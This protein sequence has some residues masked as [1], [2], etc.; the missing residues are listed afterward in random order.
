MNKSVELNSVGRRIPRID[1]ADKVTGQAR[2]TGDIVVAGML[3][4]ALVKSSHARGKIRDI[5]CDEALAV[6]GVVA[7][8]TGHD[9]K[10]TDCVSPY[11][12]VVARDRRLLPTDEVRFVG[13]AVAV[14]VARSRDIAREAAGLVEIDV[15]E[16]P[17][18]TTLSEAMAPDAPLVHSEGYEPA[19]ELYNA[20]A[21]MH[22]GSSNV[23]MTYETSKGDVT[24]AFAAA[25]QVVEG[26]YSFPG[27]Y[28]Y[29]MEPFCVLADADQRNVV[30]WSSAQHPN[31]VQADIARMWDRPLSGVRV[32]AT[33]LG[34]G[35]GSKS[36]SHVEPM[37]VA[38]SLTVGA[39][40]RIELDI[41]E[42]M[43][44]SRRHGME[45]RIRTAIDAN[46][47]IT[48]VTAELDYDGG[49]YTLLGPYVVTK[50]AFRALGGYN[51]D[52]YRVTSS[53]VYTNTSPAGSFRAIGGPQAA[54]AMESHIDEVARVLGREPLDVRASLV[55]KRGDEFR[56]GRTPMDGDTGD[57]LAALIALRAEARRDTANELGP[58]WRRG[59]G[60]AL[61]VSDPGAS[62]VSS[63]IVRLLADGSVSV[64]VGSTELG[65]GVRTVITQIVA[66]TMHVD[67]SVVRVVYTDTGSGPYDAS[68]GASR[69]TTM[70]GLAAHRAAQSIVDR[71]L[72]FVAERESCTAE[73]LEVRDGEVV[74]PGGGTVPMGLVVQQVFG[75]RGGNLIGVGEVTQHEFPT[76]PAFWEVSAGT[77]EVAVDT[78]TGEIRVLG[79][80]TTSDVGR[81]IN[82]VTM[83]GQ[84]EG[85][86]A[87]GLGHALFEEMRWDAGQPVTDSLVNYRVPRAVDM[88]RWFK[89]VQIE[90][91]DGPGA[92][93]LKGGG[94]GPIVPAAG[95]IG[96]ALRD[97]CG[98]Q[99]K[100]LPLRAERVWRALVD[101]G[102]AQN[103][104]S[105][106][107]RTT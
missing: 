49:A 43:A 12:G 17:A 104:F 94:E 79:Y 95:A 32:I 9:L 53:L 67:V 39:P 50:G 48:G 69:S 106:T 66:E 27:V 87:Q 100:D 88:P 92:F 97:A 10:A 3:H 1:G 20:P 22:W 6:P 23:V 51:F 105:A 34:G 93:G 70:S 81:A 80:G 24:A 8:V 40:V 29:A 84:E 62:P 55:A 82:P 60:L 47:R 102:V 28:H 68:T 75:Q 73:E 33:Y 5:V 76:T 99:I 45:G 77:A 42:S 30:V 65:Q 46:G 44:V 71:V 89:S 107:E 15:E 58:E 52:A 25:A 78:G 103:H 96:N 2:Y 18:A 21:E 85:A 11:F 56:P 57:T 7:V 16:L 91:A 54:W 13:E 61:G 74:L 36:F 90:N 37:A 59:S 38:A 35:F 98:V 14:V 101:A 63:A 86:F 72:R 31:Q 83:E 26:T 19:G 41:A 64:A 4:G